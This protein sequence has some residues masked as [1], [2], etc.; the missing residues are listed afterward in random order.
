M[1]QHL[2]NAKFRVSIFSTGRKIEGKTKNIKN[3]T[4]NVPKQLNC[5]KTQ[6]LNEIERK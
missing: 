1:L 6:V 2:Q 4:K 5:Q 3:F